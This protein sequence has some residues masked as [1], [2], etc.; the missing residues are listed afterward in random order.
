MGTGH[1][2]LY[3]E[4]IMPV[5][6]INPPE[7]AGRRSLEVIMASSPPDQS[8]DREG[9]G[10]VTMTDAL[11][12]YEATP[13]MVIDDA[14]FPD[15]TRLVGW[16]YIALGGGKK[17]IADVLASD[18]GEYHESSAPAEPVV[19][20]DEQLAQHV[21]AAGLVAEDH[22]QDHENYEARMLSLVHDQ[23][24]YLWCHADTPYHE[25][26]FVTLADTPRI[27]STE[28]ILRIWSEKAYKR[29]EIRHADE[30]EAGG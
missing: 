28:E 1:A 3:G 8:F 25:D 30:S 6:A 26:F 11:P 16:R 24:P 10:N 27:I 9:G 21:I 22:A 15:N 23:T 5:T 4:V 17:T 7:N 20:F 14:A 13:E 2:H 19:N 18:G 12:L 29:L